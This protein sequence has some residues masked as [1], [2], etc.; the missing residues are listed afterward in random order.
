MLPNS[1]LPHQPS[2]VS[3]RLAIQRVWLRCPCPGRGPPALLLVRTTFKKVPSLKA[4]FV[5]LPN[6]QWCEPPLRQKPLSDSSAPLGVQNLFVL[7]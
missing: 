2:P 6:R 5:H 1:L 7:T 4:H 3:W